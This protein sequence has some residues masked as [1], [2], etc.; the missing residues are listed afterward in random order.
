MQRLPSGVRSLTFFLS[1]SPEL[2][3][4]SSGNFF[5]KRSVCVPLPTPG[6]PTNIMRAA[7]DNRGDA[8]ADVCNTIRCF[9]DHCNGRC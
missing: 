9:R 3:E 1:K 6:A 7:R 2:M 5:I 8:M 4:E